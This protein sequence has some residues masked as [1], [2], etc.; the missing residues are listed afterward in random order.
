MNV[1]LGDE[2]RSPPHH[3]SHGHQKLNKQCHWVRFSMRFDGSN[4]LS[5]ETVKSLVGRPFRPPSG[6]RHKRL[7]RQKSRRVSR[8]VLFI[9]AADFQSGVVLRKRWL[10]DL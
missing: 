5:R 6:V 7:K 10:S 8:R 9:D 2:M 1:R 3:V 4:K